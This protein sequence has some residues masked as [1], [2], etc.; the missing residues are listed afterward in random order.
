MDEQ[1]DL[2]FEAENK[3][4][5]VIIGIIIFV[6]LVIGAI[7]SGNK[8]KKSN[9]VSYDSSA[10]ESDQPASPLAVERLNVCFHHAT[11][12][13][14]GFYDTIMLRVNING[15]DIDGELSNYPA[16]K[17]SKIG[18]YKGTVGQADPITGERIATVWW[19]AVAEGT[20]V[21][22]ELIFKFTNTTATLQTGAMMDKGD[23]TYVYQDKTKLTNSVPLGQ[24]ACDSLTEK[25]TEMWITK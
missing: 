18:L 24:M 9:E 6:I 16:E 3:N 19:D 4:K 10:I 5:K 21:T 2:G 14:R 25:K 7:W 20:Q 22:E 13:K 1:T 11:K 23:G 8:L 12:T 17:D 15:T